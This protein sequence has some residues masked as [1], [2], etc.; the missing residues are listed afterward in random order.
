MPVS[1]AELTEVKVFYLADLLGPIMISQSPLAQ[2]LLG[3][4]H[5]L[6]F[7]EEADISEGSIRG[8]RDEIPGSMHHRIILPSVES[9]LIWWFT[10]ATPLSQQSWLNLPL[11]E[12]PHLHEV[13]FL[14]CCHQNRLIGY[15]FDTTD[16]MIC[17]H[18]CVYLLLIQIPER[19]LSIH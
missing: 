4:V 1:F 2:V 14:G 9:D 12:E 8:A 6:K 5:A 3:K 16:R 17:S 13:A 15:K 11:L 19:D 10:M 18:R 7:V